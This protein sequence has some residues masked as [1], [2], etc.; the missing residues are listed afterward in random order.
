MN[1]NPKYKEYDVCI[2]GAGIAG[3]FLA[4]LLG[5]QGKKIL[6]LEKNAKVNMN[7]ADILKPS[8]INV[9]EKHGLLQELM[10][11]ECR[12][13]DQLSVFH[14]GI[15][16]DHINYKAENERGYFM[17]CPYSVLLETIYNKIQDIET[18]ELWVNQSISK[19]NEVENGV[20]VTLT[21]GEEIFSN[22]LIGAD[23]T[24]SIVREYAGIKAHFDYY[25][26]VMYFNKYPITSS[27]EELNRL[28]VDKN[29]GLAYFYPINNTEARCILGFNIEEG[30]ILK[31]SGNKE[32]LINR[33][34]TFVTQSD[35]MLNQINSLDNFLTFP[36][37]K[38]HSEQ[39]FK[40]KI[41]LLGNSAHSI[42]PI[43]GQ[44]MNL[45]IEDTE[46]L[47]IWL[48]K[49]FD[50]EISLEE[51]LAGYQKQRFELNS[52]VLAYGHRLAGSLG[53]A[54]D[55]MNSLNSKIQTSSR[56]LSILD[57]I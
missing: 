39:Y 10:N 19:I 38:M 24:K 3:I 17:V 18:V 1:Q 43:T 47:F 40:G 20:Y 29:G 55:F 36:L 21:S 16:V 45:A 22:I 37:C 27:V 11:K 12:V 31:E 4:W 23:G 7:G 15:Q 35:D 48:S 56:D 28:Y 50:G 13:R 53:N 9:L 26:H 34:K 49:Y 32:I 41:L 51:A 8:G 30:K 54:E 14:N 46:E 57:K 44:G 6:I 5:S 42:H 52:K 25:D 2:V 33:L